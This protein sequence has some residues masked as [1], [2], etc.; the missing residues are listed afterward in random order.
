M[1]ENLSQHEETSDFEL[2][3]KSLKL[4]TPTTGNQISGMPKS[5][6]PWKKGSSK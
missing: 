2:E 5:G 4:R 3:V 1:T 6:K